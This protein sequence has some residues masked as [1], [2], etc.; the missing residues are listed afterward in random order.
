[1]NLEDGEIPSVLLDTRKR[2]RIFHAAETHFEQL[3]ALVN[4]ANDTARRHAILPAH[5]FSPIHPKCIVVNDMFNRCNMDLDPTVIGFGA[6]YFQR[7]MPGMFIVHGTLRVT[8]VVNNIDAVLTYL[9]CL[10]IAEDLVGS[11]NGG[12][13]FFYTAQ[14][15][16]FRYVI[17]GR[18][19]IQERILKLLDFR[20]GP[21]LIDM[22]GAQQKSLD[23][24]A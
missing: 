12:V 2:Q 14:R 7:A 13:S 15:A 20:L 21:I 4:S 23:G 3:H 16:L 1:M 5:G 6:T 11:N 19:E 8:A 22:D 10:D 9:C 18:R 17:I 24:N